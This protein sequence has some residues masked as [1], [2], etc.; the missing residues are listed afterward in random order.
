MLT[1]GTDRGGGDAQALFVAQ[2][3]IAFV[4]VEQADAKRG[5]RVAETVLRALPRWFGLEEPVRAYVADAAV[6][7]TFVASDRDEDV[8]FATLKRHTPAAAEITAMGVLP[9]HHRRGAGRALVEA[10]AAAARG[11]GVRLLQVKTLGPSHPS[12]AYAATRA[13]YAALGF[14]P[15]EETGAVWGPANPCLILVRVLDP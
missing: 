11:D 2:R 5:R 3:T 14:L 9:A 7:P 8:G 10:A 15:L 13:F 4:V 6:H 1:G 12:E